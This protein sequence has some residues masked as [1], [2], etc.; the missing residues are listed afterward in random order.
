MT[1]TSPLRR[2]TFEELPAAAREA[3]RPRYERLGYLGEVFSL[4][5]NSESSLLALLAFADG[6]GQPATPVQR[7]VVALAVSQV[8][9]ALSELY[10]HEQRALKVGMSIEDVAAVESLDPAHPDLDADA[11]VVLRLAVA[12]ARGDWTAARDALAAAGERFGDEVA[13]ALLM[14]TGYYVMAN[15]VGHVLDL[16]P[17]VPSIFDRDAT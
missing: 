16:T 11:A 1:D 13:A 14:Q 7:E 8:N 5:G 3:V 4:V 6:A 15:A 10:Q 12:T 2:L 9:R 17:P